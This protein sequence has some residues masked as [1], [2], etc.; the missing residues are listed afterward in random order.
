M[1]Y[2]KA[3]ELFEKVNIDLSQDMYDKF[4]KYEELLLSWNEKINLTAIVDDEEIWLKHFIDS[5]VI[6]EYIKP[7]TSL[8]DVGTGAGFPSIP[9]RIVRGD[10]TLTL[11]DSLNKRIN[12][13]SELCGNLGI[14]NTDF[15]HG[16]AEDFGQDRKFREQFDYVTARAVANLSTL[17]ELC[18]PFVKIG[19][20]FICMKSGDVKEEVLEAK[21][22]I[23]TLGGEITDTVFYDLPNTDIKRCLIIIKKVKNTPDIYPRKAGIPNKKP[24]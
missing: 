16:R 11:L 12:F 1:I 7:N 6:S 21:N 19:G 24:L 15:V 23:E 2:D 22:S 13:L 17:C 20:E 18:I 10:I 4:C 3:K 5:A 8:I 14:E 9:C